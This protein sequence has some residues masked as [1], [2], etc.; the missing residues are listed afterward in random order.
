MKLAK[1]RRDTVFL[2]VLAVVILV[3]CGAIHHFFFRTEYAPGYTESA[4]LAVQIGDSRERVIELLGEPLR[5]HEWDTIGE[6]LIYSRSPTG[7][8]FRLRTI[9]INS[10]GYVRQ[11]HRIF[12]FD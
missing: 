5:V 1:L 10:E 8:H 12:W 2:L 11:V 7:K 6:T 9:S 4:F 3:G